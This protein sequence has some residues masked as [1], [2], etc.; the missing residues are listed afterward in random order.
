[1]G[2]YLQQNCKVFEGKK[3]I[4]NYYYAIMNKTSLEPKAKAFVD[5]VTQ[6][7]LLE[8]TKVDNA[9]L[10]E[11]IPASVKDLQAW[12]EIQARITKGNK[13]KDINKRYIVAHRINKIYCK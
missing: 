9:P 11:V 5:A 1:M 4:D 7:A 2:W 6:A 13:K 10:R 8:R 3:S 12:D